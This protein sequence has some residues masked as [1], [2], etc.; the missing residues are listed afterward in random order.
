MKTKS[1]GLVFLY[2]GLYAIS[3]NYSELAHLE[4]SIF[5]I[6]DEIDSCIQVGFNKSALENYAQ[7][8]IAPDLVR[9]IGKFG[10]F[11]NQI[12]NA[13]WNNIDFD[14]EEDWQLARKWARSLLN[15]LGM[16][17]NGWNKE[18]TQIIFLDS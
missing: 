17:M 12:D 10:E 3:S 13:R 15:K 18:G 8:G 16:K 9:E 6:M 4:S 5:E 14:I 11:V 7:S 2:N 1:T